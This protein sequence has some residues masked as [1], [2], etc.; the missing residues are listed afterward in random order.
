MA[1]SMASNLPR[2]EWLS[3]VVLILSGTLEDAG[4]GILPTA[5]LRKTSYLATKCSALPFSTEKALRLP[6]NVKPIP[7][8]PARVTFEPSE[9]R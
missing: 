3:Q 5:V 2:L 8:G 9:L 4:N 6:E 7:D 1:M